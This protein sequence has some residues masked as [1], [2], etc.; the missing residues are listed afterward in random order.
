MNTFDVQPLDEPLRPL[1]D[2]F[3]R[4]HRSPMRAASDAQLWVAR[5]PQIIGGL[6]LTP[7]ADGRW[8]TGLLVDPAWRGQAVASRLIE[9][10]LLQQPGPTWLFC[11][12]DLL[13][14]YQRSG[15]VETALLPPALADRLARYQRSKALLAMVRIGG[16]SALT[17]Q[18]PDQAP[19][20]TPR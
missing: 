14:F 10:A 9:Q 11:H 8:L 17:R 7:V 18:P 5:A 12:P 19:E 20:T 2:K 4:A 3:Y 6:C 15:F 1:L 13:G 16:F